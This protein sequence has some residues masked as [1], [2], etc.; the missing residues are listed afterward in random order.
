MDLKSIMKNFIISVSTLMIIPFL[1]NAS[2][3]YEKSEFTVGLAGQ[4]G[5]EY[6]GSDKYDTDIAPFIS[7]RNGDYYMDVVNGLGYITEF[8]NGFYLGQNLGYSL[9]R[10]DNSNTW[11]QQGSK[12][13][14]GMGKIKAAMTTT[15]T[16]GW[17]M[18]HWLG[19]EGNIEAPLTDSQGIQYSIKL[20]AILFDDNT[21]TIT[22]SVERNYGDARFNNTWYGVNKRQSQES[23]L[24]RYSAGRGLNNTDYAINWQHV[25]TDSWIGYSD[26]HYTALADRISDSPIVDKNDAFTITLGAFYTF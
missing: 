22:V 7:W 25:F 20:N 15:S 21:D 14:R 3:H 26:L 4:Y 1:A 19:F 2:A 17:W 5:P 24:N 6:T 23:G 11:L 16:L 13:L 18:T 8:D 9:G 12:N 10:S